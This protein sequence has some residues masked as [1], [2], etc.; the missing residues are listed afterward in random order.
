MAYEFLRDS[1]PAHRRRRYGDMEFDWE[2]RVNT[3]AA[4]VTWRSRLLGMLNS[5]YQ[6]IPP[7]QFREM[8]TALA[9]YLGGDKTL[10]GFTFIDIGS[11]KG[12]ALLLASQFGFRR[13]IGVEL[14]PELDQVARE[15]ILQFEPHG[16]T[17]RIEL[18]CG[19]ATTFCLPVE[20]MVIFLF[21]PLPEPAL[22]AFL[23]N[24]ER[25]L[26]EFP[27]PTFVVYA[28]PIFAQTFSDFRSLQMLGGTHQS[29]LF[30]SAAG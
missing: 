2:Y 26:L 25:S 6:P 14:L 7:E 20:P 11:G 21:N 5:T 19:D 12:R 17:S 13:I 27:R 9:D 18:I 10:S 16:E 4:T 30:R 3:T 23:E 24:T 22:R 1:L 8:M 15:N 28:N 29:L